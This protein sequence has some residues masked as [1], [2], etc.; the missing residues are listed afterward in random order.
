MSWKSREVH[1]YNSLWADMSSDVQR[2]CCL[3]LCAGR[4]FLRAKRAEIAGYTMSLAH[5]IWP[6]SKVLDKAFSL[7]VLYAY[8]TPIL[9]G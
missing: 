5:D 8:F 9:L 1:L 4:R 2:K 6:S 3:A 7:F